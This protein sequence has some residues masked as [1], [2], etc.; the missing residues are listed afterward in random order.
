MKARAENKVDPAKVRR[1]REQVVR[2]RRLQILKE[3]LKKDT[4]DTCR[5]EY[6]KDYKLNLYAAKLKQKWLSNLARNI[7]ISTCF[8][9]I[10]KHL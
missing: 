9:K 7:A 5:W 1:Y 10:L 6:L 8:I 2:K 4:F 3:K